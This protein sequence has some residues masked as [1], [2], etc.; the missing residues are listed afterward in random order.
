MKR[1]SF[2]H[3]FCQGPVRNLLRAAAAALA[4]GAA[5][6][7]FAERVDNFML[8]DQN[9]KAQELYYQ[10]DA[11]AVVI[12]I[13]GNGCPIVRNAASDLQTL[14]A[15][16]ADRGVRVF[17]LNANI[18][19]DRA[20][21][22]AEAAEYGIELPILVDDTQLVA[23]SLGVI[24]TAETFVIDP[25][26]WELVYR[27]PMHD[28][29]TYEHQKPAATET[30]L[31]D[32]LDALLDGKPVEVA[33][34]DAVGCL[35]N[36]PARNEDHSQ[37]SYSDTIAPMLK[38]NCTVC[39]SPGGIGP[40]AMTSYTMV[41]GFAPMIREVLMTQRMPPWQADPH[42]GHWQG[43][44]S[45][46]DAD[47]RTLVHWIEA[48][49]PRGD[50]PDPLTEVQPIA[51]EWPL[52]EPDLVIEVP[53]TEV[54]ASGV[55]DYQ[56]PAV[57]NPLE[58]GVWVRAATVVPGDRAAVHH[59]LVGSTETYDP[60]ADDSESIFE[61]YIIGYAP[62]AESYIMPE[63]TGVYVAPGGVYNFQLHYTPYGKATVDRTRLG[64]YFAKDRPDNFLRHQVVLDPT[65]RIEPNNSDYEEA[66][67]HQFTRDAVLYTLFPHSHYRG[68]A[69]TFE[70]VYPDGRQEMLLSVPAYDFNWQRGYDFVEPMQVPA[71]S[72]LIHRTVYDN[73]AKNPANPDPSRT[74]PWGLQSWD[75]MLYG[76]FSYA[77][78]EETSE[79][80][81][82]NQQLSEIAQWFGFID[83][84]MDGKLVWSE[85]PD[86]MKKRL[87]QGFK[88]ADT[89]GDGGLDINEFV[90]LQQRQAQAQAGQDGEQT[91]GR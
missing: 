36:F 26:T 43:D 69:S 24:R 89:N 14:A 41:R 64:L 39:H 25:R 56:F 22:A 40:W 53:A 4:L 60:E 44:R 82:H 52:G 42:V 87:V 6:G 21:I 80:P 31:R 84:D 16:Y 11:K 72:K 50:G 48:G 18:Q 47:K 19:D 57:A 28:R 73:S 9:G 61:N 67:Y 35:I 78:A 30:Y 74:V 20:S 81:I 45:L 65:I 66:A 8:L 70:L 33:S 32:S 12:M 83:H 38:E 85:M 46:A 3:A 76:A 77:W 23:E 51:A 86:R 5:G 17:M 71:G 88:M 62:G 37:I 7:A 54:P 15:D 13:H 75:E 55:V 68:K 34:R 91:S 59:V 79:H 1:Q 90:A 27:G 58:E 29:I 10:S 2:C 49:A 63:G